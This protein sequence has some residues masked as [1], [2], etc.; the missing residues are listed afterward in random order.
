MQ[1]IDRLGLMTY[2]FEGSWSEK[3]GFNAC[4]KAPEGASQLT[5]IEKVMDDLK[6]MHGLDESYYG[7]ISIGIGFYGRS[8]GGVAK[9]LDGKSLP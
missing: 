4:L 8:H 6:S 3:V 5:N 9:N 7:K 1:Y 2:D